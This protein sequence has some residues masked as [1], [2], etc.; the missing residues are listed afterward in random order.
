MFSKVAFFAVL[1]VSAAHA[2][3]SGKVIAINVLHMFNGD[4]MAEDIFAPDAV[5]EDNVNSPGNPVKGVAAIQAMVGGYKLMLN[6]IHFDVEKTIAGPISEAGTFVA[7]WWG[8]GTHT[9]TLMGLEPLGTGKQEY[10]GVNRYTVNAAGLVT[11]V[12]VMHGDLLLEKTGHLNKMVVDTKA[13]AAAWIGFWNSE[14]GMDDVIQNIVSA[15]FKFIDR[16]NLAG[17]MPNAAVE[18]VAGLKALRGMYLTAFPDMKFS[19]V[20][21]T[22]LSGDKFIIAWTFTGTH[23][24]PMGAVPATGVHI[25]EHDGANICT[26]KAGVMTSCSVQHS[27]FLL[28]VLGVLGGGGGAAKEEL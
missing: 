19:K 22:P 24:G 20:D 11:K 28:N 8:T 5:W 4:V 2:A 10:E 9:G 25:P 1:L 3:P 12:Q 15:D 21:A 7:S 14:D 17:S 27:A 13:L 26:V 16:I 18:G 23:D 6:D